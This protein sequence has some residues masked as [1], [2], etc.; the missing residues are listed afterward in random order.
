VRIAKYKGCKRCGG[1]LY[2]ERDYHGVYLACLQCG[3]RHVVPNN[4][5]EKILVPVRLSVRR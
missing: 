1:D 2:L 5:L 3:A 4:L